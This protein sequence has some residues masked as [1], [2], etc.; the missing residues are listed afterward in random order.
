MLGG[1]SHLKIIDFGTAYLFKS[2]EINLLETINKFRNAEKGEQDPFLD[3]QVKHKAT[4][5]GT[6]E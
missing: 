2:I 3:Y 1:N 4:F 6:A 5:V